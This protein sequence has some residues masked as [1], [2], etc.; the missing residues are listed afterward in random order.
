MKNRSILSKLLLLL[1]LT[2]VIGT[3]VTTYVVSNRIKTVLDEELHEEISIII[4]SLDWAIEPL[5]DGEHDD[6]IQ[7]L[8]DKISRYPIVKNIR[9]YRPEQQIQFSNL[10]LEQDSFIPNACVAAVFENGDS[11]KSIEDIE[12]R[13]YEAAMPIKGSALSDDSSIKAVLYISADMDYVVDLWNDIISDFQIVFIIANIMLVLVI[14]IYIYFMVGRPL[15]E[16]TIASEAIANNN[17]DYQINTKMQGEFIDLKESYDN[18]RLGIKEYI[19]ELDEA[20]TIVEEASDAKMIFLTNMSHEIRTPLNSILGFTDLLEE[21]ETDPDKISQLKIIHKSG[22]HLLS[23]I[24]DILDFSKLD[25]GQMDVETIT[26]SIRELVRD[27]SDFFY[28]E[29]RKRN[30]E[31]RYEVSSRVPMQCRSDMNKIRQILIN[32]ISNAMKFTAHGEIFVEVDCI[33]EKLIIKV[34]DTGIGISES[35]LETI[36]ETFSQSDNTIARKYGGT[37]LGLSICKKF[38]HLLNGNITVTSTV[39]EG[40]CFTVEIEV[41]PLESKVLVGRGILCSWLNADSELADLVYETVITLRERL[42]EVKE[43]Y[44]NNEMQVFGEQIHALKGLTGN[45]QMNQLYTLLVSADKELK[46]ENTNKE[47]LDEILMDIEEVVVTV[48]QAAETHCLSIDSEEGINTIVDADKKLN[49]ELLPMKILIAEDIRENQ[50]LLERMLKPFTYELVF[51]NNGVEA[52]EQLQQN[53]YDCMLLDIQMPEMSGE[54]VLENLQEDDWIL[55]IVHRPHIIVLTAHATMDEKERCL[56]LGADD[57]LSK[58]INKDR[59]RDKL[60]VVNE[61]L[62]I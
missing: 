30:L 45:F 62:K 61:S 32:L 15:K 16:F 56:T 37:G 5:L 53:K 2:L 51:V 28:L 52:M 29:L 44:K 3:Y 60:K 24:N 38:A 6:E 41:I 47:Y 26:F 11:F 31:Y 36:F 48:S 10:I 12:N 42:D 58:P 43:S 34:S 21:Q 7:V 59:L 9:L 23:V 4:Q 18:M 49:K 27:T 25:N 13:I 39:G 8:I 35:K 54:D 22:T 17:Y 19:N 1:I 20:K 50:L 46:K 55:K 40:S 57:Y 33:D 14:S